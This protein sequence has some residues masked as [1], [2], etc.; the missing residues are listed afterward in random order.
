MCRVPHRFGWGVAIT[1]L[2]AALAIGTASADTAAGRKLSA[3]G[4]LAQAEAEWKANAA[5][6]NVEAQFRLGELY[7][8]IRGDYPAAEGWYTKAAERGNIQARY[9]LALIA[10][11]GNSDI[12]PDPVKAYKW[13]VLASD[14]N[15]Q[16]GRL[17]E[18]LRSQ[19]DAVLTA[20]ERG[21]AR[22]QAE[23]WRQQR[24]GRPTTLARA[25][26]EPSVPTPAVPN[27]GGAPRPSPDAAPPDHG[28]KSG[29]C[30][31]GWPE[32]AE[33]AVAPPPTEPPSQLPPLAL[34]TPPPAPNRP[35][36]ADGEK[37]LAEAMQRVQCGSLRKTTNEQGKPVITGAVAND[38]EKSNLIQVSNTL[39]PGHRPEIQVRVVPPP[40][41]RSLSDL[42]GLRSASLVA[43][44]LDARLNDG[45]NDGPGAI[46]KEGDPI[47]IKVK[48]GDYPVDLRIDYFSLDGQVLHMVPN[49]HMPSVRLAAGA[50]RIFGAGGGE[51]WRAGGPPFGT[52]LILVIATPQ[53]LD[54]GP[55]PVVEDAAAY[56]SDLGKALRQR[57]A[58]AAQPGLL[59]TMLVETR[60]K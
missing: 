41:C 10:L 37:A 50:T 23:L 33:C 29:P 15:D 46:L 9:R 43:D 14:P 19:L 26:A 25:V 57:G 32:G 8:Q 31:P 18:D 20:G 17:A 54:L 30:P 51:D 56:L 38:T 49:E 40:L 45:L 2:A 24:T 35:P 39:A 53:P 21:D 4:D 6:G 11:A 3:Q 12:A 42:D 47:G 48:A 5:Q 55:R 60:A 52:E 44:G 13:A 58:G 34:V 22:R 1:A 59:T 27:P 16:W 28:A 7:E 36:P